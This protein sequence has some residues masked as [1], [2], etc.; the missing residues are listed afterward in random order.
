MVGSPYEFTHNNIKTA[1]FPLWSARSNWTDDTVMTVAVAEPLLD[2]N[3]DAQ[4]TRVG[5]INAMRKYGQMYPDAGYGHRF[6][7]WLRSHDAAP[8]GSFGNGSAMR[9]SPVAW[10]FD[11]LATVLEFARLSAEI[12]HNHPEGIK[13]AEATAAAIFMARQGEPKAAIRDYVETRFGYDLSRTP[14]KIR[15]HYVHVESCQET[16]PEALI[17]FLHSDGFEDAIRIAVSLGG[18]SDTLAAITGSVAE[19]AYGVPEDIR[20]EALRGL[21]APLLAVFNEFSSRFCPS[22]PA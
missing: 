20:Q 22:R 5:W 16:V 2:E 14:E 21:D 7:R 11:D 13:G 9:V 17:A 18:D 8:Y 10:R 4:H 12:T 1:E 3:C 19:A 15:P 6:S